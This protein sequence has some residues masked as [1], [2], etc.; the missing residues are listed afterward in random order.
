MCAVAVRKS[1]V[2]RSIRSQS[3]KPVSAVGTVRTRPTISASAQACAA[4]FSAIPTLLSTAAI[5]ANV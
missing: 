1:G 2:P 4:A 5:V 3:A